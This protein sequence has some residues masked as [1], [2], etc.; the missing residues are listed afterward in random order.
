[1]PKVTLADIASDYVRQHRVERQ[2]SQLS[3]NDKVALTVIQNKWARLYS[4]EPMSIADAPQTVVRS[5]ETTQ[6]GHELFARTKEANSVVYYTL[7]KQGE[8]GKCN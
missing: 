2:T 8:C 5:I 3:S 7:R 4:Q 1:M 6:R